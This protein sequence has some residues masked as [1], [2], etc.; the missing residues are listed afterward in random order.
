LQHNFGKDDFEI[1]SQGDSL[2]KLAAKSK[3]DETYEA[4]EDIKGAN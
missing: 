2:F 3:I 4:I 1:I